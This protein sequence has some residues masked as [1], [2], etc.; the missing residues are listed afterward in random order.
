MRG[1]SA[2]GLGFAFTLLHPQIHLVGVRLIKILSCW[3]NSE[4]KMVV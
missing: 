4:S 1:V 2:G 3:K